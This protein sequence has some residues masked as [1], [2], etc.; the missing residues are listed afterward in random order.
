MDPGPVVH[1][2]ACR[3]WYPTK[4][5]QV[6]PGPFKLTPKCLTA[7]LEK[8]VKRLVF[9]VRNVQIMACPK[10]KHRGFCEAVGEQVPPMTQILCNIGRETRGQRLKWD[11]DN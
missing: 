6:P 2:V 10:G 4:R 8:N 3:R 9:V 5:V 7:K 1:I 11:R